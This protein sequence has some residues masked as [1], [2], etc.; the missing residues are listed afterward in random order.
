MERTERMHVLVTGHLGYIGPAAVSALLA[1]GHK[2]AGLDSGLFEGAALEPAP[3]VPTD[4]KDLR[5]VRVADLDGFEAVIHLAALSND[6]LG[7]LDARLTAEINGEATIRLAKLAREAGVKRFLMSSSCSVYGA[8]VDTWVDEST[9]GRPITPY[10]ESKLRAEE[11]LAQLS[12]SDFCVICLRNA[13]A[14]GYSPNLRTDVV[15]NDL[16]AGAVLSGQV[17]LLSDGTA[18]RPLVH[19]R[20]IADAFVHALSAPMRPVNGAVVNIG[21]NDQNYTVMEIAKEVVR[22]V[23]ESRLVIAEGASADRRSYRVRFDRV[24]DV[25]PSFKCRYPLAAGIEDLATNFRRVGLKSIDSCVRLDFLRRRIEG[26][27]IDSS[28]RPRRRVSG[29][30]LQP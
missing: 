28:L 10:G 12:G 24:N 3:T 4:F 15:V 19:I 30:V 8:A 21:A 9:P 14:F 1:Q 29:P 18:W 25:L 17:R 6:P 2:V 11:G 22:A 23:P 13:T 7:L 5:D 16:V 26:G 27:E 20:D